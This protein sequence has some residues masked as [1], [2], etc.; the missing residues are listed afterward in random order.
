M[1]SVECAVM[2]R[3]RIELA[4]HAQDLLIQVVSAAPRA[5]IYAWTRIAMSLF[6]FFVYLLAGP[7]V[8]ALT[9]GRGSVQRWEVLWIDVR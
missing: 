6:H 9:E 2:T 7:F 5:C 8:V 4:L 3:V 1:C